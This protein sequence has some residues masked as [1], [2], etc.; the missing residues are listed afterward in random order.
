MAKR[1]LFIHGR[2]PKPDKNDLQTLWFN[3]I[4][5][6]LL[7]DYGESRVQAFKQIEKRFIY[8]GDLSNELLEA[9]TEHPQSRIDALDKLKQYPRNGFTKTNYKKVSKAGFL[10]EA[11]ADTF[12]A[13]LG[14]LKLAEP[15]IT[16]VAPDMAHY[17]NEDSYYGSDLRSR[18]TKELKE[19]L[20]SGDEVV[21]VAH[22][23]GSMISY[24]C[25]WKLSH[26]GE[27]R[28]DYGAEKKVDLLITLGSPLGDENV[29]ARLKGSSLSGKKR[30]PLNLHQWCNIS[31]ED[32]YISHDN[33]IKNDFKEMLQLGLVKG[34]MKD[35]YPIYNLCV[36]DKQSN[37]HSAIGYLVHPKFVTV[38]N[39]WM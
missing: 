29:K 4:Q 16:S 34:G 37:P 25:L 15:L 30:Y 31:A 12:S 5:H 7:R 36:R 8:Y 27:Y 11:L 18:L 9:P 10:A 2:A 21:M 38:L 24:D 20:D 3:A 13:V 39:Q 22:S 19:A 23:L 35:I 28:H 6:G 26:Y 32:D 14:H 1:I 33:R 17:W